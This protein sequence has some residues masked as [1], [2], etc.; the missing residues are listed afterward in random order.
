MAIRSTISP[1]VAIALTALLAGG[2]AP[3]LEAKKSDKRESL[4]RWIDGPVRYII[5]RPESKQF[6]ALENDNDRSLFV[7]RFWM[8][9]DPDP[10]TLVNEYR[11]LFWQRVKEA[12]D[13]IVDSSRPGWMTDRG[14]VYVLYGPPTEIQDMPHADTESTVTSGRGLIRWI[15]QGRPGERLD[16]DAIVVVPFVRDVSGEY[17]LSY[18]P[19]LSSVFLDESAV[20]DNVH[21]PFE[22]MMNALALSRESELSVMLD[23]GKMHEVPPAEQVLIERIE[24][25]TS[26]RTTPLDVQID[27][28]R[29]SERDLVMFSITTH[30]PDADAAQLPAMMARL[31]SRDT[32]MPERIIGEGSFKFVPDEAG[33]YLAQGR[34][35]LPPATWDVVVVAADPLSAATGMYRS[36]VVSTAPTGRLAISDVIVAEAMEPVEVRALVTYAEPFVVGPFRI[37]PQAGRPFHP[38]G[39]L[40]LFFEIYDGTPP[41]RVSYA[42]EGQDDDGAWIALGRPSVQDA[43][44]ATQGWQLPLGAR[45]PL[46][47]YRVQVTVTDAQDDVVTASVPFT[48]GEAP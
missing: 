11:Q 28:F 40:E 45:W 46:G 29:D 43:A 2:A 47:S 9:R 39:D 33:G 16:L 21:G 6:R 35:D 23:L 19:R 30:F 26:Y 18:D 25:T 44:P 36:T 7:E 37:I 42:L 41:Y 14:K 31:T 8:R 3:S 22:G 5:S 4:A 24:T 48:L 1:V 32:T 20:R 15:Y 17:R 13:T 12:N 34:V 10:E 27:R 38:G